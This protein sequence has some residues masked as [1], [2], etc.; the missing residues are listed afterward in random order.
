[1]DDDPDIRDGLRRIVEQLGAEVVAE[2]EDGRHGIECAK[3]SNPELILLDVSMPGM[4]GFAAARQ[5][6]VLLPHVPIIFVSQHSSRIYAEE[7]LH[8]G[9]R[10]YVLKRSAT[11]D[12]RPAISAVMTGHTF[13]SP[14]VPIADRVR[15]SV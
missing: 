14:L 5:L 11:T 7:A 4:G 1:M 10:A 8:I 3:A 15:H 9:V 6:R 2:A 13:V 12:L